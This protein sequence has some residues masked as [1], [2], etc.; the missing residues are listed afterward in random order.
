MIRYKT[1]DPGLS[2]T[3]QTNEFKIR[4]T[5]DNFSLIIFPETF[6]KEINRFFD[7]G[8]LTVKSLHYDG[9]L[10]QLQNLDFKESKNLITA[11]I[12]FKKINWH[13]PLP[14]LEKVTGFFEYKSGDG[15][16]EIE[17]ARFGDLSIANIKGTVKDVMN[18]PLVDLS[19]ESELD[20]RR[21]NHA[22][23]KSITGQSFEKILDDYQE[24]EGSG[25]LEA[26]L[27]GPLEELE[28][29]SVTAILSHKK[30]LFL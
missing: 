4:E 3:V 20:L 25:L 10:K 14:P 2:F 18:N 5:R 24:V 6:H 17:D 19:I 12:G 26:K 15:F 29:I 23:K 16:I 1:R 9:S 27:R 13:S 21:L 30:S 11:E 28:K 8:T 22:L 7:N